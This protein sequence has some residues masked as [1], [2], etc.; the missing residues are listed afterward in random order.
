ML[1]CLAQPINHGG[2][3]LHMAPPP[4]HQQ[5]PRPQ[6]LFFGTLNICDIRVFGIVQA[7]QEV[8][9]GGFDLT[10]LT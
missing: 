5:T 1:M 2:Y 7:I 3:C 8:Q 9:I 10:I 4:P 6:G